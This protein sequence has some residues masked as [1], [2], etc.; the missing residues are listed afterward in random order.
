MLH[1]LTIV[2]RNILHACIGNLNTDIQIPMFS[3]NMFQKKEKIWIL[4]EVTFILFSE[5]KTLGL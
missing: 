5:R 4:F 3:K 2:V 1:I